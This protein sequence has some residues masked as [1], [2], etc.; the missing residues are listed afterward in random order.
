MVK[1]TGSFVC[2]ADNFIRDTLVLLVME[3]QKLISFMIATFPVGLLTSILVTVAYCISIAMVKT[4][5]FWIS[6]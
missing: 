4:C 5:M 6:A 1:T 3:E 2:V